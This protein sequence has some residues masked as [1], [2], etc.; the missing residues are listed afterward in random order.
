MRPI[1]WRICPGSTWQPFLA[2][3][4]SGRAFRYGLEAWLAYVYGRP[5]VQL[6]SS[7]LRQSEPVILWGFVSLTVLGAA[8][9]VWKLRRVS[10]RERSYRSMHPSQAK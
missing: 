10:P 7:T 2:A 6:W 8:W 5:I 9:G 3:F 1:L 4:G